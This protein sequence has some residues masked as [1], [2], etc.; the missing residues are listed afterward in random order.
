MIGKDTTTSKKSVSRPPALIITVGLL[1]LICLGL[2]GLAIYKSG[3]LGLAGQPSGTAN[4][5]T[6]EKL[7][8]Q[9]M[10]ISNNHC[11][12]IGINEVCYGNNSIQADLLP[13]AGAVFDKTGDTVPINLLQHLSTS[14]LD[15]NKNE[16]GIA[17]FNI[18][19][20]LPRSLPGESVKMVVFGNT[21]IGNNQVGDI[22]SF[23]FSSELG[24]IICDDVPFDGIMI[25]MPDGTGVHLII[26]GSD[27][28]LSGNASLTAQKNGT[29][30]ITLYS[31]SGSITA[32]GKTQDFNA[33]E[34]IKV[35]MGGDNGTDSIGPPTK[36]SPI[37]PGDFG[38]F[39]AFTGLNCPPKTGKTTT[40]STLIP[41]RTVYPTRT[42]ILT[43]TFMPSNTP[44]FGPTLIVT[45]T[46]IKIIP[47][48]TIKPP[49]TPS[50]GTSTPVPPQNTT[51]RLP[52]KTPPG[53][54]KKT[55]RPTQTD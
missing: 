18:I 7:I 37:P 32:D 15:L 41:S 34:V 44:I 52:K 16:W 20:N 50:V 27:L 55:P 42:I 24:Q 35:P 3:F 36:P 14:P 25:T 9:A 12:K 10:R 29:M 4:G 23:Y 8:E 2:W 53:Q 5:L 21:T 48:E 33:G 46:A 11:D 47:S 28:T 31:G 45:Q 1:A 17:V 54:E 49:N 19:A 22:Q 38:N 51:T 43:G 40:P 39:C 13:S 26:N 6:C 30:D